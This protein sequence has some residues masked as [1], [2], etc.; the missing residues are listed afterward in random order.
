[1]FARRAGGPYFLSHCAPHRSPFST[2]TRTLADPLPPLNGRPT[3]TIVDSSVRVG[4]LA[5]KIAIFAKKK[6]RKCLGKLFDMLSLPLATEC[7]NEFPSRQLGNIPQTRRKEEQ[8]M[9][10][11]EKKKKTIKEGL[12]RGWRTGGTGAYAP[13]IIIAR[14]ES[15]IAPPPPC[16][17][18][19]PDSRRLYAKVSKDLSFR[20]PSPPL[21]LSHRQL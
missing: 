21:F 19:A 11:Q 3:E 14:P 16:P 17:L 18:P 2:L 7:S 20:E 15:Y 6:P 9:E 5:G 12:A 8:G 1:M 10:E 13:I 4:C